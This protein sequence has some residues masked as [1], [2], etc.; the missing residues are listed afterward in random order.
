MVLERGEV[1]AR[2]LTDAGVHRPMI[3]PMCDEGLL[4]HVRYGVYGRGPKAEQFVSSARGEVQDG[5]SVAA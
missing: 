3:G 5:L 2:E 4:C 1:R